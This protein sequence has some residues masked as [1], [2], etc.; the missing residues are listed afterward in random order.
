V[1]VASA[2]PFAGSIVGNPDDVNFAGTQVEPRLAADPTNPNHL[3]GVWQQDRWTRGLAQ[4]TVAGV[5]FD[6]GQTWSEVVVP[7]PTTASG[8]S[9][10]RTTDP[11]VSFGP[12]GSLFVS[13]LVAK[14][15]NFDK[16]Q[17]SGV[18]VSESTDGG[19]TWSAPTLLVQTVSSVVFNDKDSITADPN[20]SNMVYT[21]W[22]QVNP[23]A[24]S[25]TV[26]YLARSSDDGQ[27]WSAPEVIFQS[28]TGATNIGHQI[29][30]LPDG[31]LV[32]AFAELNPGGFGGTPASLDIIRSTDH[33]ATWSQP[34]VAANEMFF[35][36][37]DPFNSDGVRGGDFLPEVAADPANGDVYAVW[38]DD[39][40]SSNSL[41][42]IAFSM[43]SD[44]GL[45]WSSPMQINQT[46]ANVSAP[47][48]SQ[49][50]TPSI[51]VG[52]D[53]TVAVTYYDFRYQGSILGD[54]TDA[55]AVF[56]N[57]QGP[58]GLTN[59]ANWGN[60]LRLTGASF[61]L[62]NAPI[63]GG[64]FLGD[65][66]GLAAAGSNFDAFFSQAG[67]AFPQASVFSRQ[68]LSGPAGP[69]AQTPASTPAPTVV[70]LLPTQP[71]PPTGFLA[72][73]SYPVDQA[74][75][76][77]AVG[78]FTSNGIPDLVTVNSAGNT[79]SMLL[80]NGDGTF[81]SAVK[82]AVGKGPRDAAVGDFNG[83]GNLDIV[84]ANFNDIS[85]LLGTGKGTFGGPD[86]FAL[87]MV[88]GNQVDQLPVAVAVGDVNHD[89]KPDIVVAAVAALAG[90]DKGFIDVLLGQGDGSFKVG[91]ITPINSDF[92]LA[93][94]G[95]PVRI[96]LA[97]LN[98]DGNLDI[99]TANP[100][101]G[102]VTDSISVLLGNGDGTF[103]ETGDPN[104]GLSL[105]ES[106][107]VG[108]F[109]ND[110]VPDVVVN[111]FDQG[112][113]TMGV[114][115]LLGKGDGT[116][117]APQILAP[118]GIDAQS[119]AVA[120]FNRDGSLDIVAP[121][122]SSGTVTVFL[123]NGNGTFQ[124]PLNF[125]SGANEPGAVAVGDFNRDGFPDLAI[126]D[127]QS[128]SVEV[129]VN[130]ASWGTP[131]TSMSAPAPALAA[132]G[133]FSGSLGTTLIAP[134]LPPQVA[135]AGT[136][137]AA[138][139]YLVAEIAQ[140]G[141]LDSGLPPQAV[142][143]WSGINGPRPWFKKIVHKDR[144]APFRRPG[145]GLVHPSFRSWARSRAW[146]WDP[147][148]TGLTRPAFGTD[149]ADE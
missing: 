23:A 124:A 49:A 56:G 95:V 126:A 8:G 137:V 48:D 130:S 125:T 44:G 93:E 98:G 51:A 14:V 134:A 82:S 38:P 144:S 132:A 30:V 12:T 85:V 94:D 71:P 53:G 75:D 142:T 10:N 107:A 139:D 140:E 106:V 143:A 36:T 5:S 101:H 64:W 110:H 13:Y 89:G 20:N 60:E 100:S 115:V 131:A 135:P 42:G 147:S 72:P 113:F 70:S 41:A 114:S 11:W 63:S 105:I 21:V 87:P 141:Q 67:S 83:D 122:F 27:T 138:R 29:L 62:L 104:V 54:A 9:F 76:A 99:V 31:T 50:F 3:V 16:E 90:V 1:Q 102:N 103:R 97:D 128:N 92:S 109:N 34:I 26:T 65:Y 6:G 77:V 117:Q 35:G 133:S 66:Q 18:A 7:S 148:S 119:V 32:D 121:D 24:A 68:I 81:Q 116:F 91:S 118:Q 19:L 79:V 47:A 78:D 28:P 22:D 52:A 96:A 15:D 129:L 149:Q 45:A 2:D 88:I 55:W 84:T 112:T 73:A 25:G 37:F 46:P 127:V 61:N 108:D 17:K 80:G 120:D 4:G 146:P 33:G 69:P 74:P 111:G 40:F 145:P 57:P 58:G 136:E 123:G 39:R 59:P 86:T 43:S